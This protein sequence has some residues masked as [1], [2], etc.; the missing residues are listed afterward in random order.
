MPAIVSPMNT[1][2]RKYCARLEVRDPRDHFDEASG[3]EHC[4][5][6]D[7][8]SDSS[9][10]RDHCDNSGAE[11][12]RESNSGRQS[13]L[14]A[15]GSRDRRPGFVSA[16]QWSFGV[17]ERLGNLALGHNISVLVVDRRFGARVLEMGAS[18]SRTD[19]RSARMT[20]CGGRPQRCVEYVAA[21]QRGTA[22]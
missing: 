8:Y 15:H 12:V 22:R 13:R 7:D 21:F 3:P 16:W 9:A 14:R 11:R 19:Q 18:A 4:A 10:A 2:A 17:S 6:R 20:I 1:A 5:G